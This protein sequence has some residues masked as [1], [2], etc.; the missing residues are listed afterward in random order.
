MGHEKKTVSLVLGSGGARGLTQ[1]GVIRCL[2]AQGYEIKSIAGCSIGALIGGIYGAGKLD[3]YEQWLESLEKTDVLRFLDFS[4]NRKGLF[5]GDKIIDVL[6]DLVGDHK[7]EELPIKYTCV[8][9]DIE[10]EKEIWFTDGSLFESIR[11]SISIPSVFMPHYYRG[12]KLMDGGL[13]NPVPVAP[14]TGD[15]TDLTVAVN[16]NAK[17]ARLHEKDVQL[18][19]KTEEELN[20]FQKKLNELLERLLPEKQD[21]VPEAFTTDK[22]NMI[23]IMNHSVDIMQN[24]IAHAKMAINK[25]DIFVEIPRDA[26]G[27][28]DFHKADQLI[29]FGYQLTQEAITDWQNHRVNQL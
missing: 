27:L 24:A 28:F 9:T 8:A 11:A 13:L 19:D 17:S 18:P 7:I 12:M 29:E 1:I 26:S 21:E 16:L 14:T 2:E 3:L 20:S 6:M 23:D 25:P 5:K 4:F 15:N 10:R 22:F